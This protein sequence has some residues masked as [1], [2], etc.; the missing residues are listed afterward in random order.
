M[1][2]LNELHFALAFKLVCPAAEK[3][4][5]ARRTGKSKAQA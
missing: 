2:I 4:S 5:K 3:F 1:Q